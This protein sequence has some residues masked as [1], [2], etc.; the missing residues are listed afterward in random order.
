MRK[1]E[2]DGDARCWITGCRDEKVQVDVDSAAGGLAGTSS[3]S[4]SQRQVVV[5]SEAGGNRETDAALGKGYLHL[6]ALA[7]RQKRQKGLGTHK[8]Q[9]L[10]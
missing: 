9:R 8:Q 3:G 6:L 7:C 1:G 4:G 2:A 10:P 5:V